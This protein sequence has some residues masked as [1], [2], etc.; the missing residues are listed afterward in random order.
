MKLWQEGQTDLYCSFNTKSNLDL[1]GE[2]DL[3]LRW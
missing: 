3:V 2:L 1:M